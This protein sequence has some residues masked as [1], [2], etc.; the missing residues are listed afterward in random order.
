[1]LELT[2]QASRGQKSSTESPK[3]KNDAQATT[4]AI[5]FDDFVAPVTG[6]VC[7]VCTVWTR[8]R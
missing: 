5:I 7:V 4:E 8:M 1:M 2:I 6:F 3:K